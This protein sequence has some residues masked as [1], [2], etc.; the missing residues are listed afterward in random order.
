MNWSFDSRQH[1]CRKRFRGDTRPSRRQ[2]FSG[3][4][5][6]A[7]HFHHPFCKIYSDDDKTKVTDNKGTKISQ[8]R[9]DSFGEKEVEETERRISSKRDSQL[10]EH[11]TCV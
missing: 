7:R 5:A 2:V 4:E 1:F 9:G 11:A 6:P 8:G 10:T 3:Y